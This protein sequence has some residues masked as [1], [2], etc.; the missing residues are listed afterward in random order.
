MKTHLIF[1]TFVKNI[2]SYWFVSYS[3]FLSWIELQILVPMKIV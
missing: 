3:H 2:F 1:D